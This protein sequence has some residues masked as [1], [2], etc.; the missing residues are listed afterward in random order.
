M[1]EVASP[2]HV[3]DKA[4]RLQIFFDRI[5]TLLRTTP[6]RGLAPVSLGD[7]IFALFLPSTATGRHARSNLP[8][9]TAQR[10][11]AR[12]LCDRLARRMPLYVTSS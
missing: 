9:K 5:A 4:T 12:T 3:V 2:V 11:I 6:I 7:L 10:G 1:V 8:L